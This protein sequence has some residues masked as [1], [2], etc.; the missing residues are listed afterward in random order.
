M[1]DRSTA[2]RIYFPRWSCLQ[3]CRPRNQCLRRP[4]R[5]G[6]LRIRNAR[7]P[8]AV[9]ADE[10]AG[11]WGR[12]RLRRAEKLHPLLFGLPF[13]SSTWLFPRRV[14]GCRGMSAVRVS[15]KLAGVAAAQ[16]PLLPPRHKTGCAPGDFFDDSF[17]RPGP[18]QR[19]AV[20]K[21]GIETP[22]GGAIGDAPGTHSARQIFLTI[23]APSV[24]IAC[25][26]LATDAPLFRGD[27]AACGNGVRMIAKSGQAQIL[28]AKWR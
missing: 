7:R 1:F 23:D 4:P 20:K 19:L 24:S 26:L 14:G 16:R 3:K 17:R 9:P 21:H 18:R 13:H 8:F 28:G 25:L 15:V 2:S 22:G 10:K 6:S 27:N 12:A 11:R 5:Q